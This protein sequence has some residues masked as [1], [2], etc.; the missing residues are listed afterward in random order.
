MAYFCQRKGGARGRI[1][2]PAGAR[3][4]AGPDQEREKIKNLV[5]KVDLKQESWFGLEFIV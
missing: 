4:P 1:G 2:T 5:S 3:L